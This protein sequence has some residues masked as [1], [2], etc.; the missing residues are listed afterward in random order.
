M[1]E[2]LCFSWWHFI[3]VGHWHEQPSP[4]NDGFRTR[5]V[6]AY[7][8]LPYAATVMWGHWHLGVEEAYN[9][10][11]HHRWEATGGFCAEPPLPYSIWSL[12]WSRRRARRP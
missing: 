9:H 1:G 2:S 8:R 5:Y 11:I 10:R 12:L 6:E 4:T 3:H 7:D